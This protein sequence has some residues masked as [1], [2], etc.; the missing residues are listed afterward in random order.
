VVAPYLLGGN[1]MAQAVL[2]PTVVDFIQLATR[3]EHQ[4]LQ[5]EETC[6]AAGSA[7]AGSSLEKSRLR[8]E[9]G[10]II[11]A[12]KKPTGRMLFNPASA[13]ILE[14]GDIL[15]ALGDRRHLDELE[16]LAAN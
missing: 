14:A 9:L 10:L 11:V 3:T 15:I 7:L 1:V 16:K 12:I 6:I 4:E 5:I 13:T 8:S 2:K